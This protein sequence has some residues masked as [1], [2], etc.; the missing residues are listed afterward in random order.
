ME[1]WNEKQSRTFS[2]YYGGVGDLSNVTQQMIFFPLR[3]ISLLYKLGMKTDHKWNIWNHYI[4]ILASAGGFR[5]L[6]TLNDIQRTTIYF[7][8]AALK[9]RLQ[10]QKFPQP[11]IQC[12]KAPVDKTAL[13]MNRGR[14]YNLI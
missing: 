6:R 5:L 1:R 9:I 8:P 2:K 4:V 10:R 3:S 11:E 12:K 13:S 7:F 14:V